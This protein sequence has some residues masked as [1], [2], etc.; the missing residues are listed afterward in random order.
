MTPRGRRDVRKRKDG[1]STG[2]ERAPLVHKQ[3]DKETTQKPRQRTPVRNWAEQTKRLRKKKTTAFE[4]DRLIT[5]GKGRG[6][7]TTHKQPKRTTG[8]DKSIDNSR[9]A[10]IPK[11]VQSKKRNPQEKGGH[12]G[13]ARRTN[14]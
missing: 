14:A 1:K 13:K 3:S 7:K 9:G 12:I 6:K 5:G 10:L 2:K 4:R 11:Q 8:A